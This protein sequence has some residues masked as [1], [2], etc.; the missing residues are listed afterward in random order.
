MIDLRLSSG[1]VQ[2]QVLSKPQDDAARLLV[3]LDT[4]NFVARRNNQPIIWQQPLRRRRYDP[5]WRLAAS[6][7][8]ALPFR[9][10]DRRRNG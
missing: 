8:T 6:R 5:T 7:P 4:T 9:L 10:S 1:D 2:F 3:N